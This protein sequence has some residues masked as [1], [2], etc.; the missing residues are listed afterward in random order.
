M[1]QTNLG[2][3][4]KCRKL[5]PA[6]HVTRDGK[7][8]IAK[9][10][11]QC[12]TTEA[13]ISSDTATWSR[14]REIWHYDPT[15]GHECNVDC[16]TC[17]HLH[18]PR[19]VF[20]NVT[21]RCNM[22]CPICIANIPGMGFEFHPPLEYFER[23]LDGLA[24]FTPKPTVQLFGGEPTVRQDMF[25]I[26]RMAQERGLRVGIVTNGLKLADP[27]FCKKVC[28]SGARVLLGFD[29]RSPDIYARMR[30][31][32]GACEKKLQAIENLKQFSTRKHTIMCC[33]A[34]KINDKH[35]RDLIDFCHENREFISNL[36]LIPLTETWKEGEFETDVTTTIEDVE[37]II[38]EAFPGE[39]VEFVPAGIAWHLRRALAFFGS[40]R[41]TFGGV[42]PNC[43]SYTI[44]FSDGTRYW[45]VG[46]FLKRPL[47]EVVEESVRR[48]KAVDAKLE[49]LDP[50]KWFQRWRGRL[51]VLRTFGRLWLK[52][53]NLRAITKGSPYIAAARIVGGV[54]IGRKLKDQLRRHTRFNHIL[55]MVVLPFEEAHS[56]ES[57]RLRN[58]A[59]A[60]AFEDPDTGEVRTIPVCSWPLFRDDVERKI[61]KKYGVGQVG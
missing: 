48:A 4:E 40:P 12:G 59:A 26:I 25:E 17:G 61:A 2:V 44:L 46:H 49:R 24:R 60:F 52:A 19:M 6:R 20:L 21:N 45:P 43:E 9:D 5:V 16:R 22:N 55:G 15:E 34:R 41:V 23:V 18:H 47:D 1:P 58:C 32:P 54:M 14:K 51:I 38:G 27:G 31:N 57:E 37:Q 36:H 13:L 39:K 33:V 8:H 10:C 50:A 35:M 56:I 42:H 11:P 7:V 29:G 3:C 53:L 30:K 28:E